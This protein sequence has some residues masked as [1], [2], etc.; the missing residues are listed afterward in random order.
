MKE[1]FAD[2]EYLDVSIGEDGYFEHR[3]PDDHTVF[4]YVYEGQ[5]VFDEGG[6]KISA[7]NLV[8]FEEGDLVKVNSKGK[9]LRFLL[10]SGKP[11]NEPIVRYGPFVMNTTEEIGEAL[12]DLREGTFVK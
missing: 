7:T 10:I 9:S 1:I 12:K 5:G 8:I 2:P 4:A 3:V 11:L 6:T